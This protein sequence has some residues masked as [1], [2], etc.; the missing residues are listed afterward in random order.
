MNPS[1]SI[2]VFQIAPSIFEEINTAGNEQLN[3][4]LHFI[5]FS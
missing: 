4:T 1:L 3:S 5:G 2:V